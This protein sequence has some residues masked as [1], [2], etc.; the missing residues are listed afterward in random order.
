ME[1]FETYEYVI[2]PKKNAAQTVKKIL[3]ICLY[4]L[5]ILAWLVFGVATGLGAPLLALI[6]L[7]TWMLVFFT[8]KYVNV[9]YEYAVASGRITFS[10]IYGSRTRRTIEVFDVRDADVILP[11]GRKE[12][13]RRLDDF[14]PQHESFYISSKESENAYVALYVDSDGIRCAV[15]LEILPMLM[16]SC[17]IYNSAAVRELK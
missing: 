10:K 6:P 9:E 8:W 1:N 12:T 16:K 17:K 14:D 13:S 5:F 7:T 2:V 15:Y 3:F 11:L 4:V